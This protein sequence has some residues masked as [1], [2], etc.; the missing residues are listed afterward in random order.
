GPPGRP[1][2][3]RPRLGRDVR[4]RLRQLSGVVPRA[5]ATGGV[6][7]G[8]VCVC[9]S[10]N[11]DVFGYVERLP[12]PGETLRGSRL[13]Y[14]PGVKG[15]NQAVAVVW[16]GVDVR[17]FGTLGD[18]RF[19]ETLANALARDGIDLEAMERHGDPTGVALIL[20]AD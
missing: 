10:V 17:F 5:Q 6:L 14:A 8:K 19:G 16:L 11:M 18:D 3:P 7:M 13:V 9:G 4:G 12:A 1:G 2:R 15:A 20:V